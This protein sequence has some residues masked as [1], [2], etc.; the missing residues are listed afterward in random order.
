VYLMVRFV[1][2]LAAGL[3]ML[4]A[5]ALAKAEAS[6]PEN[7]E[8]NS[9]AARLTGAVVLVGT[10][11][12][13]TAQKRL[14]PV[15]GRVIDAA[16][17]ELGA[18]LAPPACVFIVNELAGFGKNVSGSG[19]QTGVSTEFDRLIKENKGSTFGLWD[20][21]GLSPDVTAALTNKQVV[22]LP[23][24]GGTLGAAPQNKFTGINFEPR[25]KF[26]PEP[27]SAKLGAVDIDAVKKLLESGPAGGR[28]YNTLGEQS[29]VSGGLAPHDFAI[30]QDAAPKIK[31]YLGVEM[32]A[33]TLELFA[34]H[35]LPLPGARIK[36]VKLFG[37]A[38]FAGLKPGDTISSIDQKPVAGKQAFEDAIAAKS[39]NSS[40]A[41]QVQRDGW[42]KTINVTLGEAPA[43]ASSYAL[44]PERLACLPG[45]SW[46][47]LERRCTP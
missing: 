36:E 25:L 14:G 34:G 2:Y 42:E 26:T 35:T 23:L 41:L 11:A 1:T 45:E 44:F 7:A 8:C 24:S 31:G 29:A 15:A 37:P 46:N 33:V 27:S 43:P 12:L 18:S 47:F 22:V 16:A 30:R 5:S 17:G 19:V 4:T 6:K 10:V 32:E 38:Y 20:Y 3:F 9:L 39:P 21:N 13:I 40:V 28:L